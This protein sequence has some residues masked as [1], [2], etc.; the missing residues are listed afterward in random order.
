MKIRPILGSVILSI[1]AALIFGGYASPD[2]YRRSPWVALPGLA[3]GLVTGQVYFWA[4]HKLNRPAMEPGGWF[5]ERDLKLHGRKTQVLIMTL[6]FFVGFASAGFLLL[7]SG[8]SNDWLAFG[9]AVGALTTATIGLVR[10]N[11][12]ILVARRGLPSAFYFH[13]IAY[14]SEWGGIA[15]GGLS[16]GFA[17]GWLGPVV[18]VL[19]FAAGYLITVFFFVAFF[20]IYVLGQEGRLSICQFLTESAVSGRGYPWLRRGLR[21]VG[22]RFLDVGTSVQQDELFFGSSY[23]IFEGSSVESDLY[24]LYLLGKWSSEPDTLYPV[25]RIAEWFLYRARTGSLAGFSVPLSYR[26][27]IF[28][29]SHEK[30]SNSLTAVLIIVTIGTVILGI[31]QLISHVQNG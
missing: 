22:Q 27:R 10:N 16:V 31:I 1:A 4:L 3:F 23:S 2:F 19:P 20:P 18:N 5:N 11:I 25:H 13:R 29:T 12:V 17:R 14:W 9:S 24:G 26:D 8:V 7:F 21:I 30:T 28:G 6:G 15:L